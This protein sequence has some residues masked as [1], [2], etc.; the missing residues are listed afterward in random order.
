M[1]ITQRNKGVSD[2]PELTFSALELVG[3]EGG[4][5]RGGWRS[6]HRWSSRCKSQSVGASMSRTGRSLEVSSH[7][8]KC[9]AEL[10]EEQILAQ[11]I[12]KRIE[13]KKEISLYNTPSEVFILRQWEEL[14]V[15]GVHINY[16]KQFQQIQNFTSL[17]TPQQKYF[18]CSKFILIPFSSI[19][20]ICSTGFAVV[21]WGMGKTVKFFLR[22]VKRTYFD[23]KYYRNDTKS[24]KSCPVTEALSTSESVSLA[25]PYLFLVAF[26]GRIVMM[27]LNL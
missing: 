19:P 18:K 26:L 20:S 4:R 22:S 7:N 1:R 15:R 5:G 23:L 9:I 14:I 8:L 12:G 11:E 21:M 24:Y 17:T 13:G 10:I 25:N 16:L 3:E 2:L 6:Q 27:E